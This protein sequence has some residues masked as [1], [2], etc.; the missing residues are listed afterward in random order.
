[1]SFLL[2]GQAVAVVSPHGQYRTQQRYKE[3]SKAFGGYRR[4]TMTT[5]W[6]RTTP[7]YPLFFEM[8]ST[9]LTPDDDPILTI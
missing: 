6:R 9:L 4:R 3:Q 7:I 5:S 1:M 2:P 8:K